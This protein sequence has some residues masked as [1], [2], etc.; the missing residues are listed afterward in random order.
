MSLQGHHSIQELSFPCRCLWNAVSLIA[1]ISINKSA[2]LKI[3][4]QF[5]LLITAWTHT[6]CAFIHEKLV[7]NQVISKHFFLMLNLGGKNE[8]M[9][10]VLGSSLWNLWNESPHCLLGLGWYVALYFLMT[11]LLIIKVRFCFLQW[12]K[13]SCCWCQPHISCVKECGKDHPVIWCKIRAAGKWW[14]L[15]Q[16]LPVMQYLTNSKYWIDWILLYWHFYFSEVLKF[17][18]DFKS[19]KTLH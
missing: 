3:C 13:C 7:I 17:S 10:L 16:M 12:T 6:W 2:T 8:T 19:G 15:L 18:E 9:Q 5:T 1:L 14:S 4:T 11:V